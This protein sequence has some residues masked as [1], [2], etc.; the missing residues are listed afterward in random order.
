MILLLKLVSL[1]A[2]QK[3]YKNLFLK[4]ICGIIDYDLA[5]SISIPTLPLIKMSVG[6]PYKS[7]RL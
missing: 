5:L 7:V 2:S 3:E 1:K 6:P 4:I